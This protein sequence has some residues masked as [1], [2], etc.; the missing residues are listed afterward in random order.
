MWDGFFVEGRLGAALD[1]WINQMYNPDWLYSPW[2]GF[3]VEGRLAAGLDRGI[4]QMYNTDWLKSH[5]GRF[6]R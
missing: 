2:D 5:M 3:F 1:R 4:N 6:L